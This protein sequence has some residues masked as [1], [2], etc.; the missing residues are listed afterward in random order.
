MSL[1]TPR[2]T[3]TGGPGRREHASFDAWALCAEFI[4]LMLSDAQVEAARVHRDHLVPEVD[5]DRIWRAGEDAPSDELAIGR[6][7]RVASE[8]AREIALRASESVRQPEHR[9]DEEVRAGSFVSPQPQ[10]DVAPVAPPEPVTESIAPLAAPGEPCAGLEEPVTEETEPVAAVEEHVAAPVESA[11]RVEEPVTRPEQSLPAVEEPLTTPVESV[12]R[13]DE[14]VTTPD[15]S[16]PAVEEPIT[17]PE[18]SLSAVEEPVTASV[19]S[20][21]RVDEP[22]TTPEQ[23]LPVVDEPVTAPVLL[24]TSAAGSVTLDRPDL[25]TEPGAD[26]DT[27]QQFLTGPTGV[28]EPELRAVAPKHAKA[29]HAGWFSAFTWIRNIGVIVILFVA[30]QL[31]GTAIAQGQAQ[32]QLKAQFDALRAH[33]HT[34]KATAAGPSLIAAA[35]RVPASADGS[36]LAELQIPALGVDQ[37]VVEGTTTDDLSKGPGHYVGTAAPGQAGNVAIAGHR[38]THGAP[39]NR[40]GDLRRGNRIILTTT[41]GQS[42]TYIV[43]GTPQAVS[44]NDVAV[45]NYFGDNRITLTTCTPEFSAAQRLIAVGELRQSGPPLKPPKHVTY[46]VVNTGTANWVW[47]LLPVVGIE[48]CLLVLLGMSYR[49]FDF[50]FGRVGQWLIL[51]PLWVAGLFLLF[52]TLTK[53]LPSSF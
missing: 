21:L 44:P 42:L 48:L 24:G 45:L 16:L 51:V 31:W 4:E 14:P 1:M 10:Q 23:S 39:F 41:S 30:W 12:H 49:R 52:D 26:P 18:Q 3:S 36:V 40:L 46:H 29:A 32:D 11:L 7:V 5:W 6:V 53:F 17:T 2:D 34:P 33:H 43:S 13:V 15:E 28:V 27:V 25:E 37:Y 35:A 38:T 22:V 20:V 50:W 9:V 8:V 19:E 47:S